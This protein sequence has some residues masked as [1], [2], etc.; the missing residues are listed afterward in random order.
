VPHLAAPAPLPEAFTYKLDCYMGA[1]PESVNLSCT[2]TPSIVP[3]STAKGVIQVS[4][5]IDVGPS[6]WPT[7]AYSVKAYARLQGGRTTGA[8]WDC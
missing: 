3:P 4:L 2:F 5:R 7:D 8:T 6:V 1:P